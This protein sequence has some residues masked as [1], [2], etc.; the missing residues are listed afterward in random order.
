MQ[1]IALVPWVVLAVLL[2]AFAPK[3][4]TAMVGWFLVLAGI[5]VFA[6]RFHHEGPYPF[7]GAVDF[8]SGCAALVVGALLI[9]SRWRGPREGGASSL[10]RALL[11]VS[12]IVLLLALVAFGHEA[13]EVVVLRTKG[14]EGRIRETR[15]WIVDHQGSPWVVTGRGSS[16]D[17]ALMENP[18]VEMVRRGE[19][20]CWVAERHLDRATLETVLEV[21]SKKYLAQRIALATGMWKHFSDRGDLDAIA[22]AIRFVPCPGGS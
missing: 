3:G 12:P 21:R 16:H 2:A 1:P 13:E 19:T 7:P 22:V 5:A 18:R 11:G 15:L 8:A 9:R 17:R 20:R 6:V 14:P 4:R 10:T